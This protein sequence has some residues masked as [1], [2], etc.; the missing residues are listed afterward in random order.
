MSDEGYQTEQPK[1]Y[2]ELVTVSSKIETCVGSIESAKSPLEV[3]KDSINS[4]L[5]TIGITYRK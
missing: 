5:H 3:Y 2:M 4:S 1:Q